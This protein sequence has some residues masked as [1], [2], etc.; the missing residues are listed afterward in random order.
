MDPYHWL[1]LNQ[2]VDW[3]QI[4]KNFVINDRYYRSKEKSLIDKTILPVVIMTNSID[5]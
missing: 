5:Q 4:D 3:H 2:L 1:N